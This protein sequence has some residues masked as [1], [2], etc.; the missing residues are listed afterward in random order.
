M[1]MSANALGLEPVG[2]AALTAR[3]ETGRRPPRRRTV[4]ALTDRASAPEAR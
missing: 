4:V 2:G 3:N 1:S